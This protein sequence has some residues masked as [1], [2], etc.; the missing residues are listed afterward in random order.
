M[1]DLARR[2]E[3]PHAYVFL[4]GANDA[5]RDTLGAAVGRATSFIAQL[6]EGMANGSLPAPKHLVWVTSPVRQARARRVTFFCTVT[7][8]CG[9]FCARLLSS[10]ILLRICC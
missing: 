8:F 3:R 6:A 9:S 5:A 4:Q 10:Q 1:R 2:G 7:S